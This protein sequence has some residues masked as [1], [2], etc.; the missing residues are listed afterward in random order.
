MTHRRENRLMDGLYPNRL[1]AWLPP[2]Q[3]NHP[4]EEVE[5]KDFS[6]LD[7]PI[8]TIGV[9]RRIAELESVAI[10]A[11]LN[12]RDNVCMDIGPYLA[13]QAMRR[14]M[15]QI[16]SG[17]AITK[18][19]QTVLDMVGLRKPLHMAF[20]LPNDQT[21]VWPFPFRS[22]R[23]TGSSTSTSRL[24]EPQTYERVAD[25]L[26][27]AINGWLGSLVQR[28][29]SSV[30]CK[31]VQTVVGEALDNA[32]RHS[33]ISSEDGDWSIAGFMT[34][35][36]V[37]SI[38][39]YKCHLSFMSLGA[40]IAESLQL[41]GGKTR[42]RMMEYV[43]KHRSLFNQ[44]FSEENLQ[45]VFA[46]QDGV[47]RFSEALKAQRGGTGLMD[48]LEFFAALGGISRTG[49]EPKLVILS[50]STCIIVKSPYM[51]GVRKGDRVPSGKIPPRE[52]W[53][54]DQNDPNYSPDPR[55]VFSLPAPIKGTIITMAWT[56]NPEQLSAPEKGTEQPETTEN[57]SNQSTTAEHENAND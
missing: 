34:R 36:Y 42:A 54:N 24:L 41:A 23:P 29:L 40:T 20:P 45:T 7:N 26:I 6:F 52:Q 32:E 49:W 13:L 50:G 48:V 30:G 38:W 3:R 5:L 1:K 4:L 10:E 35:R 39:E 2:L 18:P 28:E 31:Y 46:L 53:F 37:E 55:H 33:D 21:F 47:S 11:R 15:L 56:I 16:Y 25:E 17:G 43:S 51:T 57:D 44:Q 14:D 19:I 9:L 27:E 22:R 8:E 12:F